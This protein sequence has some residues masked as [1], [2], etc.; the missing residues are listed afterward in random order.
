MKKLTSQ[1]TANITITK[2][3]INAET[4][5]SLTDM[6]RHRDAENPSN[7][8]RSWIANQSN[9]EFLKEWELLNNSEFK[10]SQIRGF[11]GYE[12]YVVEQF[13]KRTGSITRFID[14]TNAL[15][16]KVVRGKYGGT[17][18]HSEIALQ[19]AN[20][21]NPAFYVHFIKDFVQMKKEQY[22]GIGQPSNVKRNL[23][24]GN[25]SL[26]VHSLVSKTDER[27]LSDPQP[28]KSRLV[29]AAEADMLNQI[30]FG[31]TA[32]EW[33]A[34]NPDKPTHHNIRD[35]ASVLDLIILNNL[36]FLDAMLI[37]W[38]CEKDERISILQEAYNFQYPLLKRSSTVEK[39][40]SLSAKL[41]GK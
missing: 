14:Y 40:E 2:Y 29:F 8:I 24:S 15:G 31:C 9:V 11:K 12:K 26:L 25:Y 7:I 20:W 33:K 4:Y 13:M 17:F 41:K 22:F 19:F 6:A 28:Y 3:E 27:L 1:E 23:T 39:M 18:G 38:N 32:K 36:E 16:L 10:P 37:Q 34:Q 30:V 35:Y 21:M 5:Y